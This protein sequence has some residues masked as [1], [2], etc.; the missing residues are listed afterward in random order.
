[1]TSKRRQILRYLD[2]P[3]PRIDITLAETTVRDI[4]KALQGELS[5]LAAVH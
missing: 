5:A 1:M 3:V 2:M 4:S